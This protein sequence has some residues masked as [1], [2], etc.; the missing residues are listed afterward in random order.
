M[1][2]IYN[3]TGINIT[4]SKLQL[5]EVVHR[6]N[7]FFVEN[8]DEEYF[9]EFLDFSSKETKIIS[10]L[11]NAF[12]EMI[13][14]N[15]LQSA[16]ISFTLPIELFKIVEIPY[17][18][19]LTGVD[20][21]AHLKWE[22]SILF[23]A[24]SSSD[25]IVQYIPVKRGS[26]SDSNHL[27]IVALLKQHLKTLHKF[28]SRNNLQ[29]K[30][31]DNPHI[32]SNLVISSNPDL[33]ERDQKMSIFI[34]DRVL[35]VILLTN[36]I[37]GYFK[38]KSLKKISEVIPKLGEIFDDLNSLNINTTEIKEIFVSGDNIGD[39]LLKQISDSRGIKLHR[40]NPFQ[41]VN[42][43]PKLKENEYFTEK[44]NSFVPSAGIA[45]RMI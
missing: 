28:C 33:S 19:S 39:S 9:F 25:F 12:D 37:P 22:L 21:T 35:S 20:L 43:P 4:S 44:F 16:N 31:A 7:R 13:L 15:P 41:S 14:R 18:Q 30:Y 1:A 8:V 2:S 45:F 11:Q 38:T 5:V 32:A 42:F 6:D 29:L 24:D 36:N 17:D 23:P 40:I 26:E 34:S 27:I 10:L 3:H